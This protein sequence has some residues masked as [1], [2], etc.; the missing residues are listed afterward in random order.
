MLSSANIGGQRSR[1]ERL[2][3]EMESFFL[4]CEGGSQGR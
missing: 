4:L 3:Y 2:K 1:V